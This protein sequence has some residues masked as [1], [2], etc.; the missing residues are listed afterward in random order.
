MYVRFE[1]TKT[2]VGAAVIET[3]RSA[4]P[5]V[6]TRTNEVDASLDPTGSAVVDV[7]SV[8]LRITVPG[9]TPLLTVT[10]IVNAAV[11]PFVKFPPGPVKVQMI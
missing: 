3:A 2:G 9:A 7:V 6:S 4:C 5:A 10:T 8:E 11:E 1:N